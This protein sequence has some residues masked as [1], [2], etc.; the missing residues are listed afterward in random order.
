M[1]NGTLR[2][3]NLLMLCRRS[4]LLLRLA[5]VSECY[6]PFSVFKPAH[7]P[8]HIMSDTSLRI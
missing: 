5:Y 7:R 2:S 1:E 3:F 4:Q 8:A 6:E